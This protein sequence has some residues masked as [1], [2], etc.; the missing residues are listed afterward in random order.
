MLINPAG[1]QSHCFPVD[2]HVVVNSYD[3]T[4]LS[5]EVTHYLAVQVSFSSIRS[6]LGQCQLEHFDL[7]GPADLSPLTPGGLLAQL[8]ANNLLGALEV[9]MEDVVMEAD[10]LKQEQEGKLVSQLS[11]GWLMR[12][13]WTAR[14][15]LPF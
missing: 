14:T 15:L 10:K 12:T 6:Q 5:P 8:H 3:D 9:V 4:L 7:G 2:T 11:T 13:V 1:C